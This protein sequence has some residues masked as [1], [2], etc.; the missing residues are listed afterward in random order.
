MN[1]MKRHGVILW[2]GLSVLSAACAKIVTESDGEREFSGNPMLFQTYSATSKAG[3]ITGTTLPENT[4]FGVFAYLQ[5]GVVGSSTAHW[6]DGG[7]KPD[8]M[9]NQ[10]VDF[11][12]TDYNYSPLQ[13]WPYNEENTISFWAYHPY[14][15]Y[16]SD[17]TGNLQFYET[18]DAGSPAYSK[19]STTGL[20]VVKYTSPE[21]PDDQ[22]DI[23]F[24]SFSNKDQTYAGCAPTPGTVHLQ[25]RH[26]LSLVEFQLA[27]GTGAQLNNLSLTRIKKTGNVEDCSAYP[28]V[29]SNVSGS[30][31]IVRS[32]VTVTGS[33]ILTMLAIPQEI[34]PEA[35]FTLNYDITFESSDPSHPDPIIYKGDNFSVKLFKNTGPVSEQYGFTAWE[36]GKHYVYKISAGLDRI[37][38]EEIM[39]AGDDWTVGNN[40]ISVPE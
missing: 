32:N 7:W 33:T 29:W 9:F 40:N 11:D 39:D 26:A 22:I 20:P 8:F 12:G 2:I 13:F 5:K 36:P 38:F 28:I 4:S 19:N 21:D 24:D 14:E 25:F 30:Y 6:S 35:T 34:D 37:E 17:N 18:A 15:A 23:L 27:E 31:D 3:V 16:S 10:K 1:N